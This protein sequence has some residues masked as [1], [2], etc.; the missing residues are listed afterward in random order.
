VFRNYF[1]ESDTRVT[2]QKYDASTMVLNGRN[3][4]K[5][6]KLTRSSMNVV[7]RDYVAYDLN[8]GRKTKYKHGF[9]LL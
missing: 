9:L 6:S 7:T 4:V 1:R 8:R 5:D 3:K 2:L